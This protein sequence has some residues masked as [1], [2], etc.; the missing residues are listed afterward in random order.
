MKAPEPVQEPKVSE[1]EAMVLNMAD[2]LSEPVV[3]K[4]DFTISML[5]VT[6]LMV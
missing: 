4:H 3:V 6:N 5:K 1:K 2:F